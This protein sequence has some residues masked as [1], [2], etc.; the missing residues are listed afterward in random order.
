MCG[1][2][3]QL[4]SSDDTT[5][6][7]YVRSSKFVSALQSLTSSGYQA[8]Q[9]HV[10]VE[11]CAAYKPFLELHKANLLIPGRTNYDLLK[12]ENVSVTKF[13]Q[14]TIHLHNSGL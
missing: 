2:I 9:S 11:L 5:A 14:L 13:H 4:T 10:F 1:L 12:I 8:I 7:K 3:G 6:T